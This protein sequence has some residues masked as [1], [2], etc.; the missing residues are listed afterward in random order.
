MEPCRRVGVDI[1]WKCNWRCRHCF[2]LRNGQLH[3]GGEVPLKEILAKIDKGRAGGL[4]HVVIVG[5]GEPSLSDNALPVIEYAKQQGMASSM[6]T[7]G[8]TG[9]ERFKRFFGAGLDH[10]HISAHGLDGTLDKITKTPGS[11]QKQTELKEW[12]VSEG[13]PYRTNVTMQILNYTEIPDMV[14]FELARSVYHFVFLG[15]LPHYEWK[16]HVN[17]VAVHPGKLRGYIEEGADRLIEKGTLFTIRYHPFCHLSPMYWKYV[18]NA[19][20]VHFDPW[21]WNY[22]LQADNLDRLRKYSVNCGES[23]SIKTE[24][25]KSCLAYRHC[26]GW[27]QR[28]ADAFNGAD[29]KAITEVP[30]EYEPVWHREGG[31]HDLNRANCQSGTIRRVENGN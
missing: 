28:Y 22:D 17:T 4:D 5:Y 30:G 20:Y 3:R 7:N 11:F 6:I 10:V 24:P 29:L 9:L 27:N 23:V 18:V 16:E 21:E 1:T 8:A 13:I 15:F 2:Y 26:G 25:C 19:R 12:L 14:D 31:L